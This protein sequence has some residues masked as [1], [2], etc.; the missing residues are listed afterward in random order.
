MIT[1]TSTGLRPVVLRASAAAIAIA[2][3]A[4]AD[5][6]QAFDD[7]PLDLGTIILNAR[8]IDETAQRRGIRL[9]RKAGFPHSENARFFAAYVYSQARGFLAGIF[10]GF[11]KAS[12][13]LPGKYRFHTC[14]SAMPLGRN[15]PGSP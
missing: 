5:A 8:K 2:V 9:G 1:M 14:Y 10:A 6:Q 13:N 11:I 7:V 15:L 4:P 3:A 12:L